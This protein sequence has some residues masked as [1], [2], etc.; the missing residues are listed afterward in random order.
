MKIDFND[1]SYMLV[2]GICSLFYVGIAFYFFH[3]TADDSYIVLRYARNLVENQELTFNTGEFVNAQ[4]S[5]FQSLLYALIHLVFGK[6]VLSIYKIL[7]MLSIFICTLLLATIFE[8]SLTKSFIIISV[9]T[10]PFVMMWTLG[11]LETSILFCLISLMLYF[12]HFRNRHTTNLIA[13]L[14]GIALITR[15]DSLL[16]SGPLILYLFFQLELIKKRTLLIL[17]Y[18]AFPLAWFTFSLYY[19]GDLLPSSFYSKAT[20]TISTGSIYYFFQGLI[21]SGILIMYLVGIFNFGK[22]RISKKIRKDW[23]LYF[24]V[25][26]IS[27]YSIM[28]IRVHMMFGY[29]LIIPYLP[30]FIHLTAIILDI[31]FITPKNLQKSFVK[32]VL[33]ALFLF[34][35]YQIYYVYN[36]ALNGLSLVGEYQKMGIY[37]YQNNFL[38]IMK[39]ESINL[40]HH[41]NKTQKFQNHKPSLMTYAEGYIPFSLSDIHV[42]GSLVSFG[43]HNG[44]EQLSKADYIHILTPRHGSISEQLGDLENGLILISDI[45]AI[46]D[47]NQ[48]NFHIYYNPNP[49]K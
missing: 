17:I 44:T 21:L 28:N 37:D 9:L 22:S 42:Y 12:H 7:M 38:E 29:R 3:F 31:R 26:L 43:L 45:S 4:T 19:Y 1:P 11:G 14:A 35:G 33:I 16:F 13:F 6:S 36:F 32:Y 48:E 34:N 15:L 25:F 24:S 10:S 5:P 49:S 30:L 18:I 46:F 27:I 20:I 2:V 47:G 23:P 40:S 41:I 39:Q 8:N